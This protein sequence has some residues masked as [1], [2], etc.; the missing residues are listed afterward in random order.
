MKD[1]IVENY[2]T[3]NKEPI[4]KILKHC[5]SNVPFYIS[6]WNFQLPEI[7]DFD[8]D[9]FL[10]I[11]PV[12]EK[13]HVRDTGDLFL[14]NCANINELI[15]ETTSGSEGQPIKC[16][17]SKSEMIGYSMDLWFMRKKLV[18]NLSPKD[19]FAH[20]YVARR[21]EGRMI[22]DPILYENNILHMSLFDMSVD[23]LKKYWKEILQ[24]K[25]RWLHGVTSTI[26]NLALIVKEYNLTRFQFDLVELTGEYLDLDKRL[27]IEEVFNCKIANMYGAREFWLLAYGCNY[28]NFHLND[29][30]VFIESV[31][32]NRYNNYELLITSL[33]NYSWPLVRYRIGDLGIIKNNNNC[34]CNIHTPYILDIYR[35]RA[36]EYCQINDVR[37]STALFS[38]I[39]KGINGKFN[40]NIIKQHQIVKT[41]HHHLQINILGDIS[42]K[43]IIEKEYNNELKKIVVDISL[44]VRFLDYI[45][46]DSK[47]GKVKEFIELS[48][49]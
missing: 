20:F 43:D 5:L 48:G 26:Y 19:R 21:R 27:I 47:T 41:S 8:Y 10:N 44:D 25:P 17:K 11:M 40:K 33:K 18:K 46:P 2:F 13:T 3:Q 36:S 34:L 29:K 39:A 4:Y 45:S 9:F 32:N 12:L 22:T 38:F 1:L 37:F 16:Y 7:N 15:V 14:S 42:F 6:N 28:G 35:G 30:S 24:F 31:F 23:M 49:K